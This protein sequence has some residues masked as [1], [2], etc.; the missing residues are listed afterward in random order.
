MFELTTVAHAAVDGTRSSLRKMTARIYQKCFFE[1]L[2]GGD[3]ADRAGLISKP[4]DHQN[5]CV[6]IGR[7]PCKR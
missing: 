2:T 4:L 6:Q 7:I 1:K 5:E 3:R